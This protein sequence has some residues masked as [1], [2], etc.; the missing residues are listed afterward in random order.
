[1]TA[2]DPLAVC[3][4]LHS[5]KSM[6]VTAETVRAKTLTAETMTA[7]T[8]TAE[9]V[10]AAQLA[11]R[12]DMQDPRGAALTRLEAQQQRQHHHQRQEQQYPWGQHE[13]QQ[14]YP[15]G[16]HEGQQ[17]HPW[18]QHE[19]QQ[20]QQQ[21]SDTH[22]VQSNTSV[23]SADL[24]TESALVPGVGSSCRLTG[25]AGNACTAGSGAVHSCSAFGGVQKELSEDEVSSGLRLEL[26]T[27]MLSRPVK[28]ESRGVP[29]DGLQ[30]QVCCALPDM[31]EMKFQDDASTMYIDL[32]KPPVFAITC[33]T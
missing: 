8:V 5:V 32:S 33:K 2:C 19:A 11:A 25:T 13:G 12:S 14:Q 4:G 20:Q 26:S 24:E 18:S 31:S 17:Q 9:T 10:S 22:S 15:W 7:R 16:R 1:M 28:S 27:D 21:Q 3:T 23:V 6:S 30:S 29:A